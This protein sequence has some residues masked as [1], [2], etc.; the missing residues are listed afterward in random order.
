[1]RRAGRRTAAG[2]VTGGVSAPSRTG[3]TPLPTTDRVTVAVTGPT[4]TFGTALVPLLAEDARVDGVIGV[5]R[6]PDSGSG[7]DRRVE[8]RRGDVR[9]PAT[10]A[11][12]LR[13][14]DVV[15]HL[16]YDV[17]G[18]TNPGTVHTTNENGVRSAFRAAVDAGARRFVHASSLAAY[19]FGA[20]HPVAVPESHPLGVDDRF[21][22]ARD[23]ARSEQV[24]AEESAGH[25]DVE[26]HV[27]RPCVVVGP[28]LV[29][30][31]LPGPL[32]V[33]GGWLGTAARTY[34]RLGLPLAVPAF[35]LQLVHQDDVGRALQRCAL[36][37][38]PP[39]PY[40]IAGD[41]TV[42]VAELTRELG[43]R[44][45]ELP[46]AVAELPSRA[47]MSLPLPNPLQWVAATTHPSIMDTTR[48]KEELGWRPRFTSLGAWRDTV[49]R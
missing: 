30:A 18:T 22:Y 45:V 48:A 25:P 46:A 3:S 14:A 5:S 44:V 10:L 13:G 2:R 1:M 36:G 35:P 6:H 11:P 34:A 43:A 42:T 19:G 15:V 38:G 27:V 29:G 16:A 23:K 37:D 8:Y 24:L 49:G 7:L 41:G 21:F 4:G 47:V 26:V 12:A 9:D 40:N 20:D 33:L 31:K 17:T 28:D 32:A 39:G